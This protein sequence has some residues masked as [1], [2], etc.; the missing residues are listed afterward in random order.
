MLSAVREAK[1]VPKHPATQQRLQ[2]TADRFLPCSTSALA[3]PKGAGTPSATHLPD[4]GSGFICRSMSMFRVGVYLYHLVEHT[5]GCR[6]TASNPAI[7]LVGSKYFNGIMLSSGVRCN[8]PT[9]EASY[10]L[11]FYIHSANELVACQEYWCS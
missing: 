6:S 4:P 7:D 10:R 9:N 11:C 1:L 2:I 3:V 5:L 8:D